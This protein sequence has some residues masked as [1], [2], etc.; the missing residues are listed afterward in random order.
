MQVLN[1]FIEREGNNIATTN[2]VIIKHNTQFRYIFVPSLVDNP[3]DPTKNVRAR[4]IV[5]KKK[6][7]ENWEDFNSLKLSDLRAGEYFNVDIPSESLDIILNYCSELKK[8]IMN[9]V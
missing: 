7:N 3:N 1:L 2:G 5:Q 8:S 4:I 9:M 6:K